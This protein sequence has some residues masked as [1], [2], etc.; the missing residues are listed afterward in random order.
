MYVCVYIYIYIHTYIH[1][2]MYIYIYTHTYSEN[3]YIYIYRLPCIIDFPLQVIPPYIYEGLHLYKTD[4][5]FSQFSYFQILHG[6]T[7]YV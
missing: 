3:I 5:Y 4:L 1:V 7:C 6:P 2:Y